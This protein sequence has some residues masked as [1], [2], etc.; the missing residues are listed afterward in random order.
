M[1]GCMY[2]TSDESARLRIPCLV[3]GGTNVVALFSRFRWWAKNALVIIACWRGG[4]VPGSLR[5]GPA[6]FGS[7]RSVSRPRMRCGDAAV[8][9]DAKLHRGRC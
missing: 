8:R 5:W 1:L 4:D 6:D 2:T 7:H 9:H 3:Y